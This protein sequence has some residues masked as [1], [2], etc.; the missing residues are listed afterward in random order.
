[1]G[2]LDR[3][4]SL[5]WVSDDVV[6]YFDITIFLVISILQQEISHICPCSKPLNHIRRETSI[7]IDLDLSALDTIDLLS[8]YAVVP[9]LEPALLGEREGV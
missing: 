1:M 8:W 4:G 2:A 7:L 5:V 6:A 9:A 3:S